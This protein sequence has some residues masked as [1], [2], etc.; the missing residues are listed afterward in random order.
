MRESGLNQPD[1][2]STGEMRF[3]PRNVEVAILR[4]STV[5]D[6]VDV[7][8]KDSLIYE[9]DDEAVPKPKLETGESIAASSTVLFPFLIVHSDVSN[10]GTSTQRGR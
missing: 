3:Q 7:G 4:L 6:G 2:N 8:I 9:A 1:P 10:S 5:T